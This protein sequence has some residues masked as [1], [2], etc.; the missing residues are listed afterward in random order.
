MVSAKLT[1]SKIINVL[2]ALQS[3]VSVA[4]ITLITLVSVKASS[5][6]N[7]PYSRYGLGDIVPSTNINSR[8]MGGISSAYTDFLSINFNN[9]A[10]YGSFQTVKEP[11]ARK[12]LYGRAI[13][14][15]GLNIETRTLREPNNVEKFSAS[16]ALFSHVQVGVPLRPNW[17][18]SFGLRPI[19]RVSYKMSNRALLIDPRS[20]RIDS[21]VTLNEGDGGSYLAS[22]GLGHKIKLST[23]QTLSFGINGGYLFGKQDYSRRRS[24]FND[25]L[26][27]NSGNWQT[28]TSYGSLYFTGGLQYQAKLNKDIFLTVG[29]H[30][31]WKQNLNAS[32]DEIAETYFF[33]E[34]SGYV[35]I[36]SISDQKNIKGKIVYPGAY[37]AGFIIEKFVTAKQA[38]WLIGIDYVQNKWSDYRIYGQVDPSVRDKWE[39]RIG[40]QLKPIPKTNY[41][42]NV[43]YRAG[44]FFGPEYIYIDKKLP[45]FGATFGLGL[46]ILNYNRQSPG[47]ATL[48][49]LAFEFIKRG[50]NDNVLKEN[51]FRLS[52]GFSLSDFWFAKKKYE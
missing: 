44:A 41:F 40:A 3:K 24:I 43:T 31:N 51:I 13:L 52:A 8:G 20:G 33:D 15:I 30:G 14:D 45:V 2:D 32:K 4:L 26:S 1:I 35:R 17:G 18:L 38:G 5:Q 16:N 28:T 46:P 37:T 39:L 6:D 47:Q 29:V 11:L 49:N 19:T 12:M 42:S 48:I 9:P 50:N 27:Y 23:S 36:D 21:A 7:S 22:V 34:S 25:S 10:S